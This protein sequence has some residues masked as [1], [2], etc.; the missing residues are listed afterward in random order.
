MLRRN[1]DS[2][3]RPSVQLLSQTILVSDNPGFFSIG[4]VSR[5][6]RPSQ[7]KRPMRRDA[8]AKAKW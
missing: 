1:E 5:C 7:G 3:V 2:M 8:D 4:A 6:P